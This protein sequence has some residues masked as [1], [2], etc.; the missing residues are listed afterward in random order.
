MLI[1]DSETLGVYLQACSGCKSSLRPAASV[2][3][4][5]PNPRSPTSQISPGQEH[6]SQPQATVQDLFRPSGDHPLS[7]LCMALQC[8][9]SNLHI[10]ITR[11]SA[12]KV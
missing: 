3:G 7:I 11:A 6:F 5:G 4:D 9:V 12:S 1:D 2:E 10:N 8:N